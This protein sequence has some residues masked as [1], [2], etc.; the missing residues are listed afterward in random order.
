MKMD[1][2]HHRGTEGTEIEN[3]R[4]YGLTGCC[5]KGFVN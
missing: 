4:C 3:E 2:V 5:P 1:M